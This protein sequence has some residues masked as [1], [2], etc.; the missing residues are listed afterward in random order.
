MQGT[1]TA[2]RHKS[3]D[4][5]HSVTPLLS[6]KTPVASRR[7]CT[8]CESHVAVVLWLPCCRDWVRSSS[9][10]LTGGL[11][12]L[13]M[14][15]QL[16]QVLANQQQQTHLMAP[17][18]KGHTSLHKGRSDDDWGIGALHMHVSCS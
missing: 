8:T 17:E 9:S 4:A 2:T 11:F 16:Q 18:M 5:S 10:G 3:I 13:Q 15:Q 14:E 7:Q 1:R 6:M 12:D